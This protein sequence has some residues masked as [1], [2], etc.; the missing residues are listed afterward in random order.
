MRGSLRQLEGKDRWQLRVYLGVDPATGK[1]RQLGRVHHGGRRSAEDALRDLIAEVEQGRGQPTRFT[2]VGQ[3][4]EMHLESRWDR[5]APNTRNE[6]RRLVESEL[7]PALG[8]VDIRRLRP[9][10]V[11]R[12]MRAIARTRP[13]TAVNA[14]ARL[15]AAYSDAMRWELVD[16]NPAAIADAP[17]VPE[18]DDTTPEIGDVSPA[19]LAAIA[20]G[21]IDV[22]VMVRVAVTTG[23]RRGELAALRWSCIDLEARK[24]RIS[25]AISIDRNGGPMKPNGMRKGVA[26]EGPTK[27]HNRKRLTIDQGTASW[28]RAL[29]TESIERAAEFA[30][31]WNPDGFVWCQRPDGLDPWWPDTFSHKWHDLAV[32]IGRPEIRL[33]DLRH[34]MITEVISAGFDI[35]IASG[36]AG[37]R[38]KTVT[39]NTYSHALPDRD[40]EVAEHLGRKLD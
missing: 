37:H 19:I 10:E 33:Q 1:K 38:S 7:V 26:V 15:R 16:R 9:L 24:V 13:R 6:A 28:L 23:A 11:E 34:A 14:L 25:R 21:D 29:R 22:A 12:A 31:E 39:L 20:A 40:V 17:S 30:M 27:T 18:R 5:W 32:A 8:E 3:L 4:L 2:T 35:T 36:R